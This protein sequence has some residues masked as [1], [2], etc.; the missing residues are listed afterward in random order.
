[1][2][3]TCKKVNWVWGHKRTRK[4][5]S[6]V[7]FSSE[8]SIK[9]PSEPESMLDKGHT[10]EKGKVLTVWPKQQ[11]VGPMDKGNSPEKIMDK[12]K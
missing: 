8:F 4:E 12:A 10:K 1:M 11:G 5:E 2:E 3:R 9:L 6:D 7:P